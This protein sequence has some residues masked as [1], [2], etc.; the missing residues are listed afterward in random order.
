MWAAL[1]PRWG[2]RQGINEGNK[3][4]ETNPSAHINLDVKGKSS[5]RFFPQPVT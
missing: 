3:E 2:E 4:N 1:G 5:T